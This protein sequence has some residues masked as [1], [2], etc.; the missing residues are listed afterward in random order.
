LPRTSVA[1]DIPRAIRLLA[2]NLQPEDEVLVT[3]SCF[4]VAETLF[5]LGF[6][7]LA[8]TRIPQPA[9]RVFDRIGED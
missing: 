5:K 9:S 1:P 3:G 8:A 7:D 4:T 2:A 6:T